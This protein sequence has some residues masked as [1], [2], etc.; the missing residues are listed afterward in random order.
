[1][2]SI[3]NI[4]PDR[5]AEHIQAIFHGLDGVTTPEQI[6]QDR[7][8]TATNI[9]FS[10]EYGGAACRRGST[11]IYQ[12]GSN[13][14]APNFL[15]IEFVNLNQGVVGDIDGNIY[16]GIGTNL[17]RL[18][19]DATAVTIG[20]FPPSTPGAGWVGTA[21]NGYAYFT[22]GNGFGTMAQLKDDGTN[23]TA[24][25]PPAPQSTLA[26]TV[27]TLTASQLLGTLT[28]SEGSLI[29]GTTTFACD[30]NT[31]RL[32]VEIA[33]PAH[34]LSTLSGNPIGDYGIV[35]VQAAVNNPTPITLVSM[36][37]GLN[38]SF[39]DYYHAELNVASFNSAQADPTA[40]VQSQI[41]IPQYIQGTNTYTGIAATQAYKNAMQQAVRTSPRAQVGRWSYAKATYNTWNIPL[42]NFQT[43]FQDPNPGSWDQVGTARIVITGTGTYTCTFTN[44][45]ISGAQTYSLNDV[46]VG[47]AWYETWAQLNPNTGDLIMESSPSPATTPLKIQNVN[48][49]LQDTSSPSGSSG[50]THR[51][52]YRQGGFLNAPYSVGTIPIGTTT[53]SDTLSDMNALALD[54]P[55]NA[56][57]RQMSELG[58]GARAMAQFYSRMFMILSTAANGNANVLAWSL[59]GQPSSFPRTSFAQVGD[60]GDVGMALIPVLPVLV[61]VNERSIYEMVG[62]YFE[63]PQA[64]YAINRSAARRGSISRLVPI[65]T[66]YGIPLIDY[67]GL[68]MYTPGGGIEA[69]IT[70]AM[71][72]IGDMFKPGAISFKGNRLPAINFDW[73]VNACSAYSDDR[74][75][76][77]VPTGTH[78]ANDTVI[79]LDFRYQSAYIYQYGTPFTVMKW[80]EFKN[81]LLVLDVNGNLIQIESPSTVDV[82]SGT[83][84]ST[85]NANIVW[86]FETREWATPQDILAENIAIQYRGGTSTVSAIY[87]QTNTIVVGTLTAGNKVWTIPALGGSF[88]NSIAFGVQGTQATG[89]QDVMYNINWDN[90]F[91]PKKVL[92]YRTD[93]DDSGTPNEKIYDVHFTDIDILA[94]NG[95]GTGTVLATSF[96]DGLAISTFTLIPPTVSKHRYEFSYPPETYGNIEYTI[97]NAGANTVFKLFGHHLGVRVEPPRVTFYDSDRVVSTEQWWRQVNADINPL[98]GTVT[99]TAYIDEAVVATFT[100]L[101]G[102]SSPSGTGR[103]TFPNA[104]PN[105][106]TYG[107]VAYVR[108]S[109]GGPFKH[110]RTWYLTEMQPDRLTFYESSH[111]VNP[112]VAVPKTWLAELNPQNGTVTGTLYLDGAVL[113]TA[114][115][116]GGVRH[117]YEVGLPNI[118]V[119]KTIKTVYSSTVPFKYWRSHIEA[120]PKPFYKNTWNVIYKKPG[121]ATQLDLAR[122]FQLDVETES[123]TA[124]LTCTWYADSNIIST[125]TFVLGSFTRTYFDRVSFPPGGFGRLF[126]LAISADQPFHYWHAPLDIERIGVKGF[127]RTIMLDGTPA[128]QQQ[129]FPGD[130]QKG[131]KP[132]LAQYYT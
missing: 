70:W 15:D 14:L 66:P 65:K 107:K 8:Q 4:S 99:A 118:T 45:Q 116:T 95:T 111:E 73:I 26:V 81:R 59:P 119:G 64:D 129:P 29:G 49:T 63:G 37:F 88:S 21:F 11:Q 109:S 110:Y 106:E 75:Y 82:V 43:I 74:L 7:V 92:Y 86:Y 23:V 117:A 112:S 67:D 80:D 46:N 48:V 115:F 123:N 31:F 18:T 61:I 33:V 20:T 91:Q 114:S 54:I 22:G 131:I 122:F 97:Y 53:F 94:A 19:T 84:T 39:N 125:N 108:Y 16:A 72:A 128:E 127:S 56:N 78:T 124:S 68:F 38:G 10:I 98:G 89:T 60:N 50:I 113:M 85:T 44:W 35:S 93:Y 32:D 27:N 69:P 79:V 101:P 132:M 100:L 96:L 3:D 28:A 121:G 51:I 2:P 24:F 13:A 104:Y 47:Y 30:P 1:M 58:G 52:F 40:L 12:F 62:N 41:T 76:I 9:D 77:A 126:Q 83:G 57:I 90:W 87:D 71:Q 36:D 102:T 25:I 55:M 42:P 34:W 5:P 17:I 120:D 105:Q 130:G 6:A 103:Q